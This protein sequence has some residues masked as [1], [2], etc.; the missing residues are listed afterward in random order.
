[1]VAEGTQTAEQALVKLQAEYN[2]NEPTEPWPF[3]GHIQQIPERLN[4]TSS[5]QAL[6]SASARWRAAQAL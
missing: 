2:L 1:M 6:L 3:V 4:R 5:Q